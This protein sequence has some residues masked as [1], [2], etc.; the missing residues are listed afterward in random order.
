[1]EYRTCLGSTGAGA[2][3]LAAAFYEGKEVLS[4]IPRSESVKASEVSPG[5]GS[6]TEPPSSVRFFFEAF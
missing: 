6:T 1:M 2:E 4:G 3:K 5:Q